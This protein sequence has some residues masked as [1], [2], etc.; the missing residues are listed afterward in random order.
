MENTTQK[1]LLKHMLCLLYFYLY[2]LPSIALL[3]FRTGTKFVFEPHQN[4][5]KCL[6]TGYDIKR[7]RQCSTFL[8]IADPQFGTSKFPFFISLALKKVRTNKN[9]FNPLLYVTI[10]IYIKNNNTT[11]TL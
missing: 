9:I 6:W 11:V 8:E 2:T 7:W 3:L 10:T 5:I 4:V 1:K